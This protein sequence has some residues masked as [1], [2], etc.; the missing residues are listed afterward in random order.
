MLRS[1]GIEIF[2]FFVKPADFKICDVIISIAASQVTL[3]L[4]SFES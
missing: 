4:I 2:V 1:Q 3:T